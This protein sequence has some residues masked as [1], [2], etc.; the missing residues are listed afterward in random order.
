MK[1]QNKHIKVYS[2]SK[3]ITGE[4]YSIQFGS[5]LVDTTITMNQVQ[6]D[7][8]LSQTGIKITKKL[9]VKENEE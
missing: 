1:W 5:D 9:K 8:F 6:F 3:S 7:N 4:L 2:I